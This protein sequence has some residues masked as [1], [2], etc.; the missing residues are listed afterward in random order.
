MFIHKTKTWNYKNHTRPFSRCCLFKHPPTPFT[1]TYYIVAPSVSVLV[2]QTGIIEPASRTHAQTRMLHTSSIVEPDRI[3]II[4]CRRTPRAVSSGFD[5]Y[6]HIMRNLVFTCR[7][8]AEISLDSDDRNAALDTRTHSHLQLA[9]A[10]VSCRCAITSN[11][12]SPVRGFYVAGVALATASSPFGR[13]S[14]RFFPTWNS[15]FICTDCRGSDILQYVTVVLLPKSRGV[16]RLIDRGKHIRSNLAPTRPSSNRD[17]IFS[18]TMRCKLMSRIYSGGLRWDAITPTTDFWCISADS[19]VCRWLQPYRFQKLSNIYAWSYW[20]QL[21]GGVW[22][23]G[24]SCWWTVCGFS[25]G[26]P[27]SI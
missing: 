3:N 8:L 25:L 15:V 5:K 24:V 2:R 17:T 16:G 6:G 26:S 9:L 20:L 11:M 18:I 7:D 13:F 10:H 4:L 27:F 12:V 1:S 19:T 23:E 14:D 21:W 22:G